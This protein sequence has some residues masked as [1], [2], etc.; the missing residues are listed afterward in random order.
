MANHSRSEELMRQIFDFLNQ[1]KISPEE[2]FFIAEEILL[3]S[4]ERLAKLNNLSPEDIKL[5]ILKFHQGLEGL[6]SDHKTNHSPS[7]RKIPYIVGSGRGWI[8]N[9]STLTEDN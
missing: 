1:Q 8:G 7:E 6:V 9:P 2:G 4:I 5:G 3:S